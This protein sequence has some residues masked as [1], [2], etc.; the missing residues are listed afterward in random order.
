MY[1]LIIKEEKVDDRKQKLLVEVDKLLNGLAP[2]LDGK[3]R[4]QF[5][6]RFTAIKATIFE[7]NQSAS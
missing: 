2:G 5:N 4:E 7:M 6:T 3:A 1:D